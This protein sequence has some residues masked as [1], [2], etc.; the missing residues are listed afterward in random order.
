MEF[1]QQR[2]HALKQLAAGAGAVALG[3]G[4]PAL[5]QQGTIKVACVFPLS[6]MLAL[7]GTGALKGVQVAAEQINR[8]GGVLGQRI[9]LLPRDDKGSP[10]EAALV[11]REILG[12]GIKLIIA[13]S[14]TAPAMAIVNLLQENNALCLL[15]ASQI[16]SLTHENFNPSAFRANVNGRMSF[17]AATAA[18]PIAHPDVT[19][20]CCITPDI[21]FGHDNYKLFT[22]GL[23]KA[24]KTR[25]NKDVDMADPVL[26]PYP[27]TDFKVQIS[28][29]MAIPAD[30]LY[31]GVVGSEFYTFMAQARQLGV[32]NKFKVIVD[33]GQGISIGKNLGA[34]LP[35]DNL[36]TGTP[37]YPDA[38]DAN[39][40]S[41][42]LV[43]DWASVIK[44]PLENAAWNGHSAMWALAKAIGNAKSLETPV[45]RVA[46]ERVE[47]ESANGPYRFRRE[48]HQAICDIQVLKLKQKAGDPG[49]EVARVITVKG[50][51]VV[52][53]ASPGQKYSEA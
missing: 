29:L 46:L 6:G 14:L 44:E 11:G 2:R 25:L 3:R 45:V 27:A 24:Y 7:Q 30:A 26:T 4:G 32:F 48:D 16:M 18:M 13:G 38:K 36:W 20:W 53:P 17:F 12:S 23:K 33:S 22:L 37:W 34:N 31:I 52:E 35:R 19:R 15:T 5:A 40:V 42:A 39:A 43:R 28:R 8:A 1:S 10:A 21:Q 9:E 50:E 47:F 49:W 41:K 51:D